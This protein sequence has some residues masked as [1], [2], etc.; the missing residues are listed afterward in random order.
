MKQCGK[1]D[2]QCAIMSTILP[3][4]LALTV[5]KQH[6]SASSQQQS[7]LAEKM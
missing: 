1:L 2:Q 3:G 6:A 4:S 7:A 5:T